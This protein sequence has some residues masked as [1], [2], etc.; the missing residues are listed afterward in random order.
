MVYAA[1][2]LPDRRNGIR[3]PQYFTLALNRAV[4]TMRP[5]K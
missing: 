3:P 1:L 2:L 4:L 5:S